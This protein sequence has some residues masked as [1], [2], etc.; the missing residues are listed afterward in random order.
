[1][2]IRDVSAADI[3]L[4][5]EFLLRMLAE[6]SAIS[7]PAMQLDE[8]A[9]DWLA[10][11]VRASLADDE[12]VFKIAV[13][14]EEQ[15]PAVGLIEASVVQPH[16]VFAARRTCHIHSVY[17]VPERRRQGIARAMLAEILDWGRGH[18]CVEAEL[19][20]LAKNPARHLYENLGFSVFELELRRPL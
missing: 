13:T 14:E 12:H 3:P 8:L 18:K 17:V 9:P 7:D 11:R 10:G 1:M 4:S 16:P 2:K 20:V 5:V 15:Q 6:M 19:T